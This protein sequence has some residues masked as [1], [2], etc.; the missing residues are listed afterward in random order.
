[1]SFTEKDQTL[2]G[3]IT[4]KI[5]AKKVSDALHREYAELSAAVKWIGRITGIQGSTIS[6]WYRG[7]HAPESGHLLIL[8]AHYPEMLSILLELI[9]RDDLWYFAVQENIPQ[10]MYKRLEEKYPAHHFRGDKFVTPKSCD[11]QI[12]AKLNPRQI[13]FLEQ[14]RQG[15]KLQ[16]SD[17]VARWQK[18]ARTAKRDTACLIA[19]RLIKFVKSGKTGW[20]EVI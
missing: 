14:L 3:R 8:A 5:I 10:S 19:F 15:R 2:P 18:H 17:I 1:M 13:W 11:S 7:L 16:A 4:D 20:Y 6:K 12:E 9:G